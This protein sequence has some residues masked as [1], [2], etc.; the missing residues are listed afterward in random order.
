MNQSDNTKTK[1]SGQGYAVGLYSVGFTVI[2]GLVSMAACKPSIE[3]IYENSFDLRAAREL[4]SMGDGAAANY[5]LARALREPVAR[6][7]GYAFHKR[8]AAR[9]SQAA[10]CIATKRTD[11][12]INQYPRIRHK[13]L[14]QLGVCLEAAGDFEKALNSYNL[15]E[16]SGS[17]QPQ[18]YLRRGLLYEKLGRL[19]EATSD[20]QKAI[21][22]NPEY[23]PS[24]C[25]NATYQLRHGTDLWTGKAL[26]M[27]RQRHSICAEIIEDLQKHREGYGK[28]VTLG[29]QPHG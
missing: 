26:G 11:L 22:L 25:I 14:F 7:E 15:S 8:I 10:E 12:A 20:I 2:L 9:K 3:K 28:V 18:L 5:Y 23:P 17:M 1:L 13:H 4:D 21:E 16:N 19:K 27:L 24:Q 6:V 29:G